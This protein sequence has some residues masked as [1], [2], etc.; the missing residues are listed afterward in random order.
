[1]NKLT[2]EKRTQLIAIGLGMVTVMAVL[3]FALIEFQWAKLKTVGGKIV[4]AQKEIEK[5]QKVG[6]QAAEIEAELKDATGRL[7]T[8]ETTMPSGDL[9]YWFISHLKQFNTP[10]YKVEMPQVGQPTVGEVPVLANYPYHQVSIS[11]VGNA[12]YSDLGRFIAD[13]ENHFPYARLQ[14]LSV[15]PSG[16][17][18]PDEKEKLSFHMEIV[19]LLKPSNS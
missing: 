13:F 18:T 16:G 2:K 19:V 3:W 4:A 12:Y 11:V 9:F 15:E 7:Q 8:V 10:G 5:D 17:A 6:R 1:M 14:N